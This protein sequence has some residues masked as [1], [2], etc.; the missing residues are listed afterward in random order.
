[1]CIF[2]QLKY[3]PRNLSDFGM[4]DGECCERLWAFLRRFSRTTKESRPSHQRDMLTDALLY[5]GRMSSD[6]F[7]MYQNSSIVIL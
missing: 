3:S 5:Y 2:V 6:H 1:M 7:G 4:A